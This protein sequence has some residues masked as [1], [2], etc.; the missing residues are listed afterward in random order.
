MKIHIK[1]I[2]FLFYKI[3]CKLKR[4]FFSLYNDINLK[5]HN[6]QYGKK[7]KIIGAI[8]LYGQGTIKIGDYVTINSCMQANPIGGSTQTVL[9][10]FPNG[11]III[12]NG[13]G[14]SNVAICSMNLIII[15]DDVMLGGGVKIYDTDFHSTNY[16]YRMENKDIKS[17]PVIIKKGAFIGTDTIVLKGVTIGCKSV[18]GA[19][20]IVTMDIPDGEIWA[21]NPVRFIKKI[22]E[23]FVEVK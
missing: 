4:A 16:Q 11:N 2:F 14:M 1:T 10:A 13:V 12:G 3:C 7:I 5:Y 19:G 8:G 18:V 22:N 9:N 15:E 23:D 20:S 6:V 17:L 21:G